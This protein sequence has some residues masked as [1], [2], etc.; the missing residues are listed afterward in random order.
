M[1]ITNRAND[2]RDLFN[3]STRYCFY[4]HEHQHH[5]TVYDD[6]GAYSDAS[7]NRAS[8]CCDLR[9]DHYLYHHDPWYDSDSHHGASR[10]NN[11]KHLYYDSTRIDN[12]RHF[13]VSLV[14]TLAATTARWRAFLI[15]IIADLQLLL[16]VLWS[17]QYCLPSQ[18]RRLHRR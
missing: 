4:Y 14:C 6:T 9:N 11:D 17:L 3:H 10:P 8:F 2:H 13:N 7:S 15:A 18:K 12:D 16:N 5:A 1:L